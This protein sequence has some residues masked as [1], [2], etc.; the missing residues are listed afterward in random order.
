MPVDRFLRFSSR[1][2][3]GVVFTSYLVN[4]AVAVAESQ[5]LVEL[6]GCIYSAEAHLD[7]SKTL[8]TTDGKLDLPSTFASTNFAAFSRC[9]YLF[10]SHESKVAIDL[11]FDGVTNVCA[12]ILGPLQTRY[13][14]AYNF[15]SHIYILVTAKVNRKVGT[16]MASLAIPFPEGQGPIPK[17]RCDAR[18]IIWKCGL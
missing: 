16:F 9:W 11:F 5:I 10:F 7:G 15:I 4:T 2:A 8:T 13:K 3:D 17:I 6:Q 18:P 14:T 1:F 12:L